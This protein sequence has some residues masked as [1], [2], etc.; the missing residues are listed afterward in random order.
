MTRLRI[1]SILTLV[2]FVAVSM[3]LAAQDRFSLE[4]PNGVAFS[5]FKG[6][7]AWQV[8]A[9]SHTDDGL[10][11]ILGN[12]AMVNAF[13]SGFPA[14]GKP[15]PDGATMVKIEWSKTPHAASPSAVNVPGNLKS[16]AFMMKDARR[17]P[18]TNG[19][20]YAQFLYDPSSDTFKPFGNDGSFAKTCHQC[21]TRV[22]A[23]DFVFTSYAR[24]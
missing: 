24:R 9:P 3:T 13:E 10:K 20:G 11:A 16:V 17:F 18:D 15:V 1:G 4:A 14:N 22:K 7:E 5:E 6:Y 2:A 8:L 23:R 19:W 21:H 12:R